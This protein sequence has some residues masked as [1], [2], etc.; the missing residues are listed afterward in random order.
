MIF[1]CFIIGIIG[2]WFARETHEAYVRLARERAEAARAL[3]AEL[4]AFACSLSRLL[5]GSVTA[6]LAERLRA[7]GGAPR[8][9]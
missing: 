6:G 4:A 3:A 5:P 8:S 9:I 7:A 2:A 1:D